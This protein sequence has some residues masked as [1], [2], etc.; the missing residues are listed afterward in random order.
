MLQVSRE[1]AAMPSRP[2]G[3]R[4]DALSSPHCRLNRV[5]GVMERFAHRCLLIAGLTIWLSGPDAHAG[6]IVSKSPGCELSAAAVNPCSWKASNHCK[7]PD[8]PM[9]YVN[10]AAEYNRA[11]GQLNTYAEGLN[12][13]LTCVANEA[14]ADVKFVNDMVGASL[15]KT[16]AGMTADFNRSKAQLDAARLK[17][18]LQ[19]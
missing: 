16:Q 12:A 2:R 4:D 10:S 17:L 15:D 9:I 3:K 5:E 8:V 14:R 19:Q 13:Y 11:A 6:E 7:R 1:P 18:Q